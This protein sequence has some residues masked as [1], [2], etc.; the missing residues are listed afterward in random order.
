MSPGTPARLPLSTSS[1]PPNREATAAHSRLSRQ[2]NQTVASPGQGKN[3]GQVAATMVAFGIGVGIPL[4]L[5]GLASRSFLQRSRGR[6]MSLGA[7]LK[8]VL[9]AVFIS[10]G[11]LILSGLDKS[12]ETALVDA[13]PA[14]LTALTTRF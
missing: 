13:S 7:G 4:V 5:I 9:G 14:W 10:L 6:M 3:I 1:S 11:L 8:S 2:R 12:V